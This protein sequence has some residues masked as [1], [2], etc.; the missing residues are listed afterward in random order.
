MGCNTDEEILN[1][2]FTKDVRTGVEG[3]ERESGKH[4]ILSFLRFG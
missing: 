3:E 4:E 1:R 2:E